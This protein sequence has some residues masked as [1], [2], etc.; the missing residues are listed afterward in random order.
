MANLCDNHLEFTCK[1]IPSWFKQDPE[2]FSGISIEDEPRYLFLYNDFEN[3]V[4][5]ENNMHFIN[6]DGTHTFQFG[7]ETRWAPPCNLYESMV[8]DDNIINFL[9]RWFEPGCM[10][11]GYAN[12]EEWIVD[13]DCPNVHYSDFLDLDVLKEEPSDN[14]IELNGTDSWITFEEYKVEMQEKLSTASTE[15]KIIIVDEVKEL[16]EYFSD[17]ESE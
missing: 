16:T 6:D 3:I 1:V 2:A 15:D 17:E 11:L 12:K 5:P 4:N 13:E 10:V 14:Y 8:K 7:F 9:G